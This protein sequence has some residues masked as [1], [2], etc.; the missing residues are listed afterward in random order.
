MIIPIVY[1]DVTEWFMIELQGKIIMQDMCQNVGTLQKIEEKEDKVML[2]IGYHQLEGQMQALKKP[3]AV[4][5][6]DK[7]GDERGEVQYKIVGMVKHK[8]LFSK[9]PR[10]IISKPDV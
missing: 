8:V 4:L 10:A 9:Q 5:E 1:G 2:T 6:K 7:I 3:F